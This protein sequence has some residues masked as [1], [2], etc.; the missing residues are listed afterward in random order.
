MNQKRSRA[1][2][3]G[4]LVLSMLAGCGSIHAAENVQQDMILETEVPV[5][6]KAQNA[7]YGSWGRVQKT[8]GEN[9]R[10]N[11]EVYGP[12]EKKCKTYTLE[13]VECDLEKAAKILIPDDHSGHNIDRS[14]EGGWTAWTTQKGNYLCAYSGGGLSL[15]ATIPKYDEMHFLMD[16]W[17][18][19]HKN[20]PCASLDFMTPQ[21]AEAVGKKLLSE[22]GMELN[23]DLRIAC[24]LTVTEL[25]EYQ[26]QLLEKKNSGYFSSNADILKDLTEQDNSYYLVFSFSRDGIPVYGIPNED[27]V[28]YQEGKSQSPASV[29]A[30]MMISREGVTY[31]HLYGTYRVKDAGEEKNLISI[32]KVLEAYKVD[33]DELQQP[34]SD[35]EYEVNNIYLEYMPMY[36]NNVLCMVPYWRVCIKSKY[37]NTFTHK[38]EWGSS[39]YASYNGFTGED[40]AKGG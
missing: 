17:A 7:D 26:K 15:N 38:E 29:M 2:T 36:R 18:R 40:Y 16:S 31:F 4:F 27:S 20:E 13:C 12:M 32:E 24:G 22:L 3:L 23:P 37:I 30:E 6:E 9:H 5:A 8:Y 33:C 14:V 1:L 34:L 39:C 35:T 10:V 11:A 21:E 19:N 25:H 28:S